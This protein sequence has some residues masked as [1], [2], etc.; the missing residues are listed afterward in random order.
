MQ[1]STLSFI[2]AKS[3][4]TGSFSTYLLDVR[5]GVH[6]RG[7]GAPCTQTHRRQCCVLID[8]EL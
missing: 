2:A 3:G 1:R 6:A 7:C 5:V 8:K 4:A